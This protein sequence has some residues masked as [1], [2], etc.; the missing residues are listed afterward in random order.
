MTIFFVANSDS[1]TAANLAVAYRIAAPTDIRLFDKDALRGNLYLHL[2]GEK[3]AIFSMSHGSPFAIFDSQGVEAVAESDG[4]ALSGFK[5]YAWACLTAK[6]LGGILAKKNIYW[7]GYDTSV[8]APDDRQR[9]IGIFSEVLSVAKDNFEHGVDRASVETVLDLIRDA[10][11]EAELK[12][13]YIGA[14]DDE[15]AME[16]YSCCYQ[17][18]SRLCMWL[19][20]GSEPIKHAEAP[21]AYIEM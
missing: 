13:D 21:P 14:G 6:S 19:P 1:Q 8:T 17:I 9:Y 4:I 11:H 10:C 20:G 16:L 3:R 5:V 2:S 12:L 15:N 18:W 7:W